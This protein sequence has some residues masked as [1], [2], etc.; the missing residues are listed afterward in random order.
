M[1]HTPFYTNKIENT[2]V[3]RNK[4]L[5]AYTAKEKKKLCESLTQTMETLFFCFFFDI[6]IYF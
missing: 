1:V 6:K 3:S 5:L 2:T 4:I